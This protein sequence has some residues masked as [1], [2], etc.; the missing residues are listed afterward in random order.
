MH[1]TSIHQLERRFC[2]YVEILS[3]LSDFGAGAQN[4]EACTDT[5]F[6]VY[7]PRVKLNK[8]VSLLGGR[9]STATIQYMLQKEDSHPQQLSLPQNDCINTEC[10][11]QHCN[12]HVGNAMLLRSLEISVPVAQETYVEKTLA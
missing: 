9:G 7:R 10:S 2:I 8:R 6:T 4:L 3:R 5:M 12:T 11:I 1:G